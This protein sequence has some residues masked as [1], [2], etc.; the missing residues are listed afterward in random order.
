MTPP[1]LV[2]ETD[3]WTKQLVK[4][5]I[6][7]KEEFE[8]VRDSKDRYNELD[9]FWLRKSK[10]PVLSVLMV[11]KKNKVSTQT[12]TIRSPSRLLPFFASHA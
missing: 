7:H 5:M 2:S 12:H 4:E 11:K 9:T 8:R 6:A 3:T 10:Q 1:T